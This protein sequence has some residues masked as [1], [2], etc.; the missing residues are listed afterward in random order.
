MYFVFIQNI[1]EVLFFCGIVILVDLTV[2]KK[3]SYYVMGIVFGLVTIF[4]MK[5]NVWVGNG[6]LFD[7]RHITMTMAGFIGG[8]VT[9]VIAA[10]IS[11]LYRYHLGGSGLICGITDI[12]L[13]GLIGTVL[14]SH[15]R[16]RQNGKKLL[17]WFIA[18]LGMSAIV[19][20]IIAFVPPVTDIREV[21][22]PYLLFTPV[23]TCLIFNFYYWAN[24]SFSKVSILNAILKDSP[25]NL[26]A[27]DGQGPILQSENLKKEPRLSQFCASLFQF[28][29]NQTLSPRSHHQELLTDD[30]R[31][32]VGDLLLFHMPNGQRA[33]VAIVNDTTDRKEE[34]KTI[35][36]VKDRFAK[37]FE[38][39]PN[40]MAIIRKSDDQYI[41]V[42]RRFL[43]TRGLLRKDVIGK[44][45]FDLGV[46]ESGF[47]K[48]LEV[49]DSQGIV[50]NFERRLE[51]S[52]GHTIHVIL[53]AQNIQ[54]ENQD[55]ILIVYSD[56][57]E[58]RQMQIEKVTELK[59]R[60][61]LE[62][63]LSKSNQL[64]AD[65]IANMPDVFYVLDNDWRFKYVNRRAEELLGK[66]REELIDQIYWE[67]LPQKR[68]SDLEKNC[69][70]AKKNDIPII[71]ENLS[72]CEKDTW[73]QV[74][75]FPFQSGLAVYYV[76][77]TERKLMRQKLMKSEQEMASILESMTDCFFAVNE[78]LQFTYVNSA[79]EL[80]FAQTRN[81]LLGQSITEV[82]K[83][84]EIAT[85]SFKRVIREKKPLNFEIF[86][87]G[88]SDKWLEISA[89][90][91]ETGLTCF[92]RDI[93]HRKNEEKELARLDRLN[94][95]GQ[96]AAGIGHELRNPMTSV[97]GYLQLLGEKSQCE[98][99]KPIFELMISELDRANSIITEFL[100]LARTKQT[101]LK[102]QNLNDILS[103]LY[104][105]LE[106]DTFT[107]NKKLLYLPGKIPDLELDRKEISQLVLNLV[108]NGLEAMDEGKL[109]TI[110]TFL[111][112]DK[113]VLAVEDEGCGIP[114]ES[115]HNL[116][117]PFYTTKDNGTGLGLATCYK[118]A[119]SHK[120][121]IEIE[122]NANGTK[123]YILF[124]ISE[125]AHE[126]NKLIV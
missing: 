64:I 6:R 32:V 21:L 79:A 71:F 65:V 45:P 108:R 13:F 60:L 24:K 33:Y 93:T 125:G 119:E 40:M 42:N 68:G 54:I 50:K 82:Y 56:V 92:F 78:N 30:G 99:H 74:H 14:G 80:A 123:F 115:L 47:R 77:I 25:I 83:G 75:T 18:G 63:E 59:L 4:V 120:A 101:E 34:Q 58:I 126:G 87:D 16:Q 102:F 17:F 55:C 49:L 41:D 69:Y 66:R 85:Q 109:L 53:S 111:K 89:Y 61:K 29:Q 15:L 38:L 73:F 97:R 88:L 9:A 39:G 10:L 70:Q 113:V 7:F 110:R 3:Y 51:S 114:P 37:A 81:E 2:Y 44:T 96:M 43:E 46:S 94:L 48:F 91:A 117:T 35:L 1:I 31:Y 90:P 103:L 57:T 62:E 121:Q 86:S 95:V 72:L 27:F 67:V 105:L 26:M 76:D 52:T 124:P 122:S 23:A 106:A 28:Y 20:L 19:L 84:N 22:A 5:T 107:Q 116:G 11:A 118:I 100:S 104:P 112:Q 8:P 12:L 98:Q 36:R